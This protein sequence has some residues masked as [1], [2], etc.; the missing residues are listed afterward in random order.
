M[1]H[2]DDA[3]FS[4]DAVGVKVGTEWRT[5]FFSVWGCMRNGAARSTPAASGCPDSVRFG[6]AKEHRKPSMLSM[7]L[8]R[9]ND[10]DAGGIR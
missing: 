10:G 4:E 6:Y 2:S 7:S 3:M 1:V 8:L 9:E 5:I